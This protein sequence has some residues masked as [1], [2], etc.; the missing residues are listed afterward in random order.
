MVKWF[1]FK[2]CRSS[3]YFLCVHVVNIIIILIE[4]GN[5]KKCYGQPPWILFHQV[6]LKRII[7]SE[8]NIDRGRE[9]ARNC[10]AS[11]LRL[12][13]SQE[14]EK[15][16]AQVLRKCQTRLLLAKLLCRL[17][18]KVCGTKW[19]QS[20]PKYIPSYHQR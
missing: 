4:K 13:R 18:R 7:L 1:T 14:R 11:S 9:I 3:R 6:C 8:R 2:I 15:A 12:A 17:K 5:K 19:K 20:R 16:R 10:K